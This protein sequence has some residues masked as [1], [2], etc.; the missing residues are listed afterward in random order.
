MNSVLKMSKSNYAMYKN[1]G[2]N[3][4]KIY[5]GGGKI[6]IANLQS[7]TISSKKQKIAILCLIFWHYCDTMASA[8][9]FQAEG[10]GFES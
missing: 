4:R 6:K 7:G 5:N 10:R 8:S 2:Q 3:K 1:L 9:G